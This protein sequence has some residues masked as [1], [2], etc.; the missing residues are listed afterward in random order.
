MK[1]IRKRKAKKKINWREYNESLVRC[2]ELLVNT[3][4]LSNWQEELKRMNNGKQ[5]SKYRY[6]NSFVSLLATVHTYFLL[7][8]RQMEGLIKV[9]LTEEVKKL[10]AK[11]P[12]YTTIWWRVSGMKVKLDPTINPEEEKVTIA[13]DS[14]GIKVTNRGEWIRDKWKL[15]RRGFIK[16]HVAVNIKTRQIVAMEVTK[17]N[18]GDGRMLKPLV[19]YTCSKENVKTVLADGGYDSKRNFSYLDQMNIEPVIKVRKNSSM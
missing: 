4:F 19:E 17:E 14:T 2:G 13:V 15:Q 16:I 1:R 7:P 10:H 11:I 12:D 5:G 6:P 18:V 3:D 9:I 8:Y